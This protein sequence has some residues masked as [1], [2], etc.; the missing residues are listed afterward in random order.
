MMNASNISTKWMISRIKFKCLVTLESLLEGS[1]V[2]LIRRRIMQ[3]IPYEVLKMNL[4]WIYDNFKNEYLGNYS[5]D[6]F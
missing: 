2:N 5:E 6:L 3:A 4:Y 1:V